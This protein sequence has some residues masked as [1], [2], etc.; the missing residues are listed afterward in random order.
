MCNGVVSRSKDNILELDLSSRQVGPRD[1]VEVIGL[2][3]V[4]FYPQS[5]FTSTRLMGIYFNKA[6]F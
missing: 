1:Q 3:G 6:S 2:G 4:H 5:H